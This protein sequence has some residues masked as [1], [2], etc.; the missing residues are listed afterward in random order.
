MQNGQRSSDHKYKHFQA[1]IYQSLEKYHQKKSGS[2]VLFAK[3]V[4]FKNE[5]RLEKKVTRNVKYQKSALHTRWPQAKTI[6]K[7]Q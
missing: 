2:S 6:M 1:E 5:K 7:V 4:H 3:K